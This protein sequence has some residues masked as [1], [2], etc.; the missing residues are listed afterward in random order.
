MS[1]LEQLEQLV[2]EHPTDA[3]SR[4][5]LAMEYAN[6]GQ[7]EAALHQFA[8]LLEQHPDYIPGYQM[9]AQ[10][11]TREGRN[12]EARRMLN[13]GIARAQR[14]HNQKAADEMQGM[15]DLLR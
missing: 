12:D 11:L 5:G 8:K 2:T 9:S 7:T 1:R 10:T 14:A 4:Y 15:L 6:S 13:E 3:F